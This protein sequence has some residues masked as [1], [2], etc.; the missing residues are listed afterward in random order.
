MCQKSNTKYQ[1]PLKIDDQILEEVQKNIGKEWYKWN[2]KY[3]K[4]RI[5]EARASFMQL[6]YSEKAGDIS[7]SKKL[8]PFSFNVKCVLL[9]DSGIWMITKCLLQRM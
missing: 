6:A 7:T 9:Y 8:H 4:I 2:W 1:G 5:W 3:V